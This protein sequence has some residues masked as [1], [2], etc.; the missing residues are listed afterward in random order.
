MDNDKLR[1]LLKEFLDVHDEECRFDHHGY[2]QAHFLEK[3]CL[4][5]RTKRILEGDE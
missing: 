4:I 3:D 2:C 5:K 1:N